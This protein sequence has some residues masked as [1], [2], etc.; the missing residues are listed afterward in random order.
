[1]DASKLVITKEEFVENNKSNTGVRVLLGTVAVLVAILLAFGAIFGILAVSKGFSRSQRLAD[2]R[3]QVQVNDIQ[4]QQTAQLVKVQQ[5]K[6]QIKVAE[7]KGIAESQKIINNT[8]TPLYLQ[9]EAIQAQESQS[10][11]IIYVPSGN[12]GIPLVNAINP[13]Q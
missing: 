12:Q 13:Q 1:M 2:E 11:K 4:I 5:Q 9:H 7:A 3:N 10:N 8:L 6:A